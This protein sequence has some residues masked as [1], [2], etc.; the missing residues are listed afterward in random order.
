MLKVPNLTPPIIP[1]QGIRKVYVSV[2]EPASL[3]I[4][5]ILVELA[6]MGY[7]IIHN[8]DLDLKNRCD[9]T[10]EEMRKITIANLKGILESDVLIAFMNQKTYDYPEAF[11]E[12][13]IALSHKKPVVIVDSK[14]NRFI[15]ENIYY[16]AQ[17]VFKTKDSSD[18][19][20]VLNGLFENF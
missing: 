19:R 8:F 7:T 17:G 14:D 3:I 9:I 12:I 11:A 5:F 1:W 18:L 4:D 20:H 2:V 16:H 15:Q 13:G 6:D 10:P